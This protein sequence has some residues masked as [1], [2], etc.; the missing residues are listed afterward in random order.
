MYEGE[1]KSHLVVLDN[2][3]WYIALMACAVVVRKNL[4]NLCSLHYIAVH[5]G[6]KRKVK[7]L[8][9]VEKLKCLF[10]LYHQFYVY[11]CI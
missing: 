1:K 9:F 11:L 8:K 4:H 6:L 2:T 10:S 5:T 7:K 3:K